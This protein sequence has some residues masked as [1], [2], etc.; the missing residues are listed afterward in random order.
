MSKKENSKTG[1]GRIASNLF[2]ERAVIS[3]IFPPLLAALLV[4]LRFWSDTFVFPLRDFG[5]RLIGV[6]T[7]QQV[8]VA[9]RLGMFYKGLFAG[10]LAFLLTLILYRLFQR[11][12][13]KQ[14]IEISFIN[15]LSLTGI[16]LL[17]F[18][19]FGIYTRASLAMILIAAAW[20]VLMALLSSVYRRKS[21]FASNDY[22]WLFIS[23]LSLTFFIAMISGRLL[24]G[25]FA[26]SF[27]VILLL[28]SPLRIFP[29]RETFRRLLQHLKYLALSPLLFVAAQE[30]FLIFNQRDMAF[31]HPIAGC[32]LL[33]LAIYGL[34]WLRKSPASGYAALNRQF[35]PA[36]VLGIIV[37]STYSIHT[38]L[39]NELFEI[40]NSSLAMMH[41]FQYGNFPV[42]DFLSSHLLS[43]FF[44][45]VLYT[46]LN[47]Y[48]AEFSFVA[49]DFIFKSAYLFIIFLLLLKITR[50][51]WVALAGIIFF[52]FWQEVFWAVSSFPLLL[53]PFI[54]FYVYRK[55]VFRRWLWL[56]VFTLFLMAW[57]PDVAVIGLYGMVAGIII[58]LIKKRHEFRIK[59]PLLAAG[60][61]FGALLL[62]LTSLQVIFNLPVK[63]GITKTLAFYASSPQT[64]G[65]PVISHDTGRLFSMHHIV[66]P[67]IMTVIGIIAASRIGKMNN[68]NALILITLIV[69]VIFYL[70]NFQRGLTRHSFAEG[71][72]G[73]LSSFAFITMGLSVYLIKIK[74]PCRHI[75]FF[76]L[77]SFLVIM[78][79]WPDVPGASQ[80]YQ[81]F[82]KK[83]NQ[84]YL[85]TSTEKCQRT[86]FE[87]QF[88]RENIAGIKPLLEHIP[89]DRTFYDFSNTP[90]L[91]YIT[92]KEPPVYFIHQLAAGTQSLQEKEL[93]RLKSMD[94]P[95]IVY[96]HVPP[97][98]WDN[99]DGIPNGLRFYKIAEYLYQQYE[100]WKIAGG[101]AVWKQKGYQGEY[102]SHH[103]AD[104]ISTAPRTFNLHY[105]PWVWA[106]YDDAF[107]DYPVKEKSIAEVYGPA[108]KLPEDAEKKHGNYLLIEIH[109]PD[110]K[111]QKCKLEYYDDQAWQGSFA[112]MTTGKKEREKHLIRLSTQANW[113]HRD[114][115]NLVLKKD[116]NLKVI[117]MILLQAD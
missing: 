55:P 31:L 74:R 104:S 19:V 70:G 20:F 107:A 96:S 93:E 23:A 51:K 84:E 8:D 5:D 30:I 59:T 68:R 85:Y 79:S 11:R 38:P 58:I 1:S 77:T 56:F 10:L 17:A 97:D 25:N 28:M 112:F 12:F 42:A 57:K 78:L 37:F 16:F 113:Y 36:F 64:R 18:Q 32:L 6:A 54:I 94:V 73:F 98:W 100:P 67:V 47:G 114:V 41:I 71:V 108:M 95:L 14:H 49:Y 117:R 9:A 99:T 26:L 21:S 80:V 7:L 66:F 27:A 101:Y 103:P 43:D 111:V 46:I 34:S 91:Y 86:A 65:L 40:G 60:I 45:P 115:Q 2:E 106:N 105:L 61:V 109:N 48:D 22:L 75:A 44:T 4:F 35:L 39:S 110:R 53:S 82:S 63:E 52:P 69:F 83:F 3:S 33:L 88:Y 15:Y 89:E 92:G 102:A 62:M 50:N 90:A 87:E 76:G 81:K 13:K 116:E 72:D 24:A 29:K